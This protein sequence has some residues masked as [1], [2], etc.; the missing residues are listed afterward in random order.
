MNESDTKICEA[1]F[2]KAKI[3][4]NSRKVYDSKMNCYL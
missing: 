4:Q 3:R 1:Y 2:V